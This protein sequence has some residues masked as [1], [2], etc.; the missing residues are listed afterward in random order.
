[1]FQLDELYEVLENCSKDDDL[2]DFWIALF[3]IRDDYSESDLGTLKTYCEIRRVEI[4]I[5][6]LK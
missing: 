1:M 2:L 5:N 3:Y 6:K 4:K